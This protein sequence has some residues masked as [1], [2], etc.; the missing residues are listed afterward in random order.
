MESLQEN[1]V[2]EIR[3]LAVCYHTSRGDLRAVENVNLTV[4]K[5]EIIGLVGESGCG[6][7]TLGLALLRALPQ[8]AEIIGGDIRIGTVDVATLG[9][10]QLRTYRW[11]KVA[12]VFQFAMNALDPVK[13]I[14]AQMSETITQ[15]NRIGKQQALTRVRELLKMVD[16]DPLLARSYPHELSGGMRQRVVVAM[17][18]CLNPELLVA[19]EPTTALDVVVQ[20]G[21]LRTLKDLQRKL[22]L[23]VILIT[24][25]ISIMWEM[26]DRLAVMYAGKIVELGSTKE[27]IEKPLHPYTEALLNAVPEVGKSQ[28]E[29]RGI[30]G[31]PPNLIFPPSGCR[32]RSRCPYAFDKCKLEPSLM[33]V[34]SRQVAC[35]LR[36]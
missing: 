19:D 20:A 26:S 28:K 1:P 7:S 3:N 34:G 9:K 18:L 15:H 16:L 32:F 2:V 14:G 23:A 10:E 29:I 33:T 21:I 35:W 6:K 22:H 25:D 12:M 8:L 4:R 31:A 11:E 13:T 27:I 24:H 17:A 5:G 36:E 30:S